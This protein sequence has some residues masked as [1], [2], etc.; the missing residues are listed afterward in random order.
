MVGGFLCVPS[1]LNLCDR[2]LANALACLGC[3]SETGWEI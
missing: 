2:P 1:V 3:L